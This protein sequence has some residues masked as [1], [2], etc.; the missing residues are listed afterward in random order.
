MKKTEKEFLDR[1]YE[2]RDKTGHVLFSPSSMSIWNT[3]PRAFWLEQNTK[4]SEMMTDLA[5]RGTA[6]HEQVEGLWHET[7]DVNKASKEALYM[8][9]HIQDIYLNKHT[10]AY[11]KTEQVFKSNLIEGLEGTSDI[12]GV[13]AKSFFEREVYIVD[14][15]S[16]DRFQYKALNNLQLLSYG[17]LAAELMELKEF[18]LHLRIVQPNCCSF[19]S[20]NVS[21]HS[22]FSKINKIK[23]NIIENKKRYSDKC[24][25]PFCPYHGKRR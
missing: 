19:A 8:F 3:C 14:Y 17:F 25:N 20:V 18:M 22:L 13:K 23:E 12:V 6:L 10:F 15:K 5:N 16:S 2:H 21:L 4:K 1:N 9:E 11:L 7:Q 24:D